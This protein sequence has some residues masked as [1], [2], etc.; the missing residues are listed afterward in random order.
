MSRQLVERSQQGTKGQVFNIQEVVMNRFIGIRHRVKQTAAGEARPTMVVICEGDEIIVRELPDDQAEMD[1]VHGRFPVAFRP[2]ESDEDL[3]GFSNQHVQWRKLKKEEKPPEG[4]KFRIVGK[5]TQVAVRVPC[6]Y[7]GLRAGDKVG[8]I[9]GGSGDRL[10]AALSRRGEDIGATV[11][12]IPPFCL[13]ERRGDIKKDDDAA[14]LARLIQSQPRLFYQVEV[15]DRGIISVDESLRARQEAMRQRIACEQRLRA[16]FVGGLFLSE[17][18]LYPEGQ[19]E[20]EFNRRTANDVVLQNLR[21]EEGRC[22]ASLKNA[23]EATALWEKIFV[24]IEG[25][26]SRLAAAFIAGIGDIRRFETDAKLKAYCGVHVLEDGRFPR[27]RGGEVANWQP[28][29]RQALFLLGEQF[30]RRP[31]SVWGTKLKG[32]KVKLRG[33]HPHPVLVAKDAAGERHFELAPG[34][35]EH[36]KKTGEYIFTVDNRSVRVRGTQRYGDG[37]IHKMAIWR[38]LTKFVEWIFREWWALENEYQQA[39]RQAA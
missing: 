14:L 33:A 18:G 37:H 28:A 9:L 3:S 32:Y 4:S 1:F 15:R 13:K 26:G 22:N 20:D 38:T 11:W 5:E 34:T 17:E 29:L 8:L 35:F 27:K 10:A 31:D 6:Q 12:R 23:V 2:V 19:I 36:D 24:P 25:V 30:N 21:E 7:D 39:Q 16:N